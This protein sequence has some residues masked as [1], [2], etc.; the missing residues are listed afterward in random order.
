[1]DTDGRHLGDLVG[2]V[3]ITRNR[4]DELLVALQRMQT[5]SRELS[6][7]VVDNAS[8]D[9]TREQVRRS[10]PAVRLIE[11]RENLGAAARNVGVASLT[12]PYVAFADDDT[13]WEEASLRRAVELLDAIPDL[14]LVCGRFVVEP[15]GRPDPAAAVL[16]ASPLAP[17]VEAP[18]RRVL[19]FLAGASVVRRAPFLDVGGFHR[20]FLVGGEESLVA[21]DLS[22]R[23]GICHYVDDVVVHHQPST[24]RDLTRR[25][26]IEMRNDLWTAWL[27]R[28]VRDA[29]SITRRHVRRARANRAM[30][31]PL[32][33]ALR[34]AWWV[35]LERRPLPAEVAADLRLVEYGIG[36]TEDR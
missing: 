35:V 19:G 29:L 11:M 6:V 17:G 21:W 4:A 13:W 8:S 25:R 36:S 5:L 9:G 18:G 14:S 15:G 2:V 24:A 34:G 20:R 33:E 26:E 7:V 27:R 1:M 3:I 32:V 22:A 23:G 16:A 10:F 12:T 31:R 30:Y 28:P